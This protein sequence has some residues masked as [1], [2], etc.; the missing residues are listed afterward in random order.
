MKKLSVSGI[1]ALLVLFLSGIMS[2]QVATGAISGTVKDSSGAVLPRV[3]VSILNED[4]GIAREIVTDPTGRYSVLSLNL[5]HYQLTAM[6]EGFQTEI[7]RGILLTVGREA[8]VDMTLSIGGT[9]Q[10]LVVTGEVSLVE[11][12]SATLGSLVDDRAIRALPLNGRSYD[13]LALL[14]PGVILN[15]PGKTGGSPFTFG[16]GK[17][18]SVGGQRIESN[19]FLLDGTNVNDQGNGTPGGAAGTNL[20]VDTILEF[21]IFTNSY[22]AEYGRVNGSVISAVTRSG[23]NNFH[24]TAFEYFRNSVLDAPN[25]FDVDSNTPPFKRNQFGGVFGGP[26]K[27]DKTFFFGGYEGLRQGLGTTQI[28]T[29]PTALARQGNLPNGTVSVNPDIVPYLNLYP[30]PNGT[31]FGDGTGQFLSSPTVVTDEDNFMIRLDHQL[32]VRTSIFGRYSYDDDSLN[33]PQSIPNFVALSTSRRQYTTLQTTT[34]LNPKTVNH[35]LFAFNRTNSQSVLRFIPDPGPQLAL[36]PGQPFGAIQVGADTFSGTRAIT[37]LGPNVGSG[38]TTFAFNVFEYG[39]DFTHIVGKHAL[40][41]GIDIQRFRDNTSVQTALW[42]AL[43]FPTLTRFLEGT[44]SSLQASSPLGISPY[45]GLRQTLYAAYLQDDYTINSRLTMNLGLRWEATTDPYDVNGRQAILPSPLST[46]T[47]QSDTF[48]ETGKKNFEPRVGLAW[49]LNASGKTVLRT[50]AGIYHNQILPWLYGQNTSVPP[51]FGTLRASN[52][53]F[54]NSYQALQPSTSLVNLKVTAPFLKTPVNYQYNLSIQQELFKNTVVEIAYAGNKANHLVSQREADTSVPTFCDSS[55]ANCPSGLPDGTTYYAP[56]APRINPVWAGIRLLDTNA[57]SYYNSG[58]VTLRRQFA[59]GL[60]G[61]VFYSFS[62]A[63]DEVSASNNG[64]SAQ[65][66]TALLDPR[67]ISR[68]WGLSNFNATHVVVGNFSYALPFRTQAKALG[69]VAN[70]WTF[71]GIV[72]VSSG[73]PFTLRLASAVSRDQSSVL[74]ERPDLRPGFS[75]NPTSG[76]SLGCP[77]FA[78]GTPVGN[79]DHWYDPCAFTLPIPGT[80]GNLRRNTA[81]GPGLEEVDL[82]LEKN[83]KPRENINVTF[84]AEAFNV[85]NHV[86]FGLPNSTPLTSSGGANASAGVITTTNTSSRQLQFALRIAF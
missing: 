29:V 11:S 16:T 36:I 58:T 57:N 81:I 35:F 38:A 83:F 76:V 34:V 13:Q 79:A 39:D 53:P 6:A 33:A 59:N 26:I 75:S 45:W 28:A 30:L 55:L 12:T 43:T 62:K 51:F 52:P 73:Q 19:S 40:K 10:R 47:V 2:A 4:T 50:G 77:G 86:N 68:D 7:R 60:Q 22:K 24:G 65:S 20:G 1:L 71:S 49:R 44:P 5:G 41:V 31:D 78:A 27:K 21:K 17:R 23:T 72:T 80:Y 69:R 82:A 15:S 54:P 66:P 61:Q 84:R 48:F 9:Q 42:G 67:D 14:Q 46:E 18:F 25:F 32:D 8:I 85:F 63:M 56:G 3:K 70:N 74:T 64:E 37:P